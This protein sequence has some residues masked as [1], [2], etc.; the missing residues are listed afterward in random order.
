MTVASGRA[1]VSG[2][3]DHDAPSS[4]PTAPSTAA[5]MNDGTKSGGPHRSW[6]RHRG[7]GTSG[8]NWSIG[9]L[10]SRRE[11]QSRSNC[12]GCSS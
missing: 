2:V 11:V 10:W 3:V 1:S 9:N 12:L 6:L 5:S 4:M 7:V 8:E